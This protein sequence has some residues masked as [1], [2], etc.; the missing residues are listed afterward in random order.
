M[1]QPEKFLKP[2][3][4][5]RK[6]CCFPA[7]RNY[8]QLLS[9]VAVYACAACALPT[10]FFFF[11]LESN[12]I[13]GNL[14]LLF[15]VTIVLHFDMGEGNNIHRGFFKNLIFVMHS[16]DMHGFYLNA[17]SVSS[18]IFPSNP[19]CLSLVRHLKNPLWV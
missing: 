18:R 10:S 15:K 6:S 11:F 3:R 9:P 8:L 5:P 16:T 14:R 13:S 7:S 12:R 17:G 19:L 1:L 2:L 4:F